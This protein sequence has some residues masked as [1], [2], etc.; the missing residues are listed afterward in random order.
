MPVCAAYQIPMG[1]DDV[2]TIGSI[3][4]AVIFTWFLQNAPVL[5]IKGDGGYAIY[6]IHQ[7]Y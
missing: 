4:G 2:V 7:K 5:V 6:D 3:S 1:T